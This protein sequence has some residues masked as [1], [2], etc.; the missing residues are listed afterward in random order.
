MELLVR[1]YRKDGRFDLVW[2]YV[3]KYIA[4]KNRKANRTFS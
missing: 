1:V 4:I 2:F 3:G